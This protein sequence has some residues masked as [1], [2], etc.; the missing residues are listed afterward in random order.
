MDAM[1]QA[2]A[3]K[4][5]YEDFV[6]SSDWI[7]EETCD[8]L[9]VF[10]PGFRKEQLRVQITTGHNIRVSGERPLGSNK[11]SR[12]QKEFSIPAN[13]DTNGINAKFEGSILYIRQPKM[14]TAAPQQQYDTPKQD[15][16][17]PKTQDPSK[18]PPP[19]RDDIDGKNN[20]A[21]QV[22]S[23]TEKEKEPKAASDGKVAKSSLPT[24]VSNV[25]EKKL[26]EKGDGSAKARK[27]KSTTTSEKLEKLGD[28]LDDAAEMDGAA[29][30]NV[31]GGSKYT[32]EGY[33]QFVS[34]QLMELKE[35]RRLR[36][37]VV[38]AVLALALG[39][40]VAYKIRSYEIFEKN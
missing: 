22:T 24:G 4:R 34:N 32:L 19:Q 18:E 38:S 14:I 33:K 40:Y 21:Q 23:M 16:E 15:T 9:L 28:S 7:R 12:F 26:E 36:N 27:D 11:W 13:C 3:I 25:S 35:S 10:L 6:P 39:F 17:A 1:L 8:T 37:M 29:G 20:A 30:G 31:Y 2:P 5:E